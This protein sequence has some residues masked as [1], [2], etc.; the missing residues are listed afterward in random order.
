MKDKNIN[1]DFEGAL[2]EFIKSNKIEYV[3]LLLNIEM[4]N[5]LFWANPKFQNVD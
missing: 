4:L 1:A 3:K 5:Q 2:F